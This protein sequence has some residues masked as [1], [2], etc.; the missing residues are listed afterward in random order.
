MF[1][2]IAVTQAMLPLI[3]RARGRIVNMGS[4]GAGIAFPFGGVLCASKSALRSLNDA[5][6]IE[7]RCYG[8][9]VCLIEPASIRTPAADKMLGDV[10]GVIRQRPPEGTARY[11]DKLRAFTRRSYSQ[12]RNGSPP[13]VVARAV[14][15]A[16]TAQ[17]PRPCY[18]VGANAPLLAALR[19]LLPTCLLDIV[20]LRL[21]GL[22]SA[23]GSEPADSGA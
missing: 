13:E 8:I 21:L 17:R 3:R 19:R 6:R 4:V 11:G 23:F 15:R 14:H 5:L 7:L 16:L 22:P 10:E 1:G 20:R 2:Q 9:R 12:E 18:L